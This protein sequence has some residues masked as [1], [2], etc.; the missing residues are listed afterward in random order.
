MNQVAMD[1][2]IYLNIPFKDKE[3]AK[4]LGCRWDPEKKSWYCIKDKNNTSECIEKWGN[5]SHK[6]IDGKN[7]PLKDTN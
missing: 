5:K 7:I 3:E 6:I 4:S 2:R 1:S